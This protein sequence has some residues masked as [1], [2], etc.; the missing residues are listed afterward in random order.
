NNSL[1][2]YN[3]KFL[4]PSYEIYFN[5]CITIDIINAFLTSPRS[6]SAAILINNR[7]YFYGGWNINTEVSD[8]FYL[9]VSISFTNN[10]TNMPWYDRSSIPGRISRSTFTACIT[11][12]NKNQILY[13]GGRDDLTTIENFTS[14]FDTITQQ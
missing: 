8:F 1:I 2:Y 13:F 5:I 7:I 12:A 9:D 14:T 3:L 4:K 10:I 11:G 6:E